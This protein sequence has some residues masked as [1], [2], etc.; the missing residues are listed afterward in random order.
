MGVGGGAVPPPHPSPFGA[1]LGVRG[2]P[3]EPESHNIVTML[4]RTSALSKLSQRVAARGMGAGMGGGGHGN[5][6][7]PH[8]LPN[9]S[10]KPQSAAM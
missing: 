3:K 9:S 5:F 7:P 8:P 10:P 1:R 6:P 2:Q 4:F